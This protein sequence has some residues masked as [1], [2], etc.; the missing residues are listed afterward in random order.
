MECKCLV[1]KK[2]EGVLHPSGRDYACTECGLIHEAKPSPVI[3][4]FGLEDATPAAR[5][6][7]KT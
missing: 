1:L 4:E 5:V 3:I 6:R 7:E 2:I